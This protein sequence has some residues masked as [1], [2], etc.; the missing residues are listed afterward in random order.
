M[1]INFLSFQAVIFCHTKSTA[2]WL[3]NKMHTEGYVVA[4]LSDELDV[5]Q[6]YYFSFFSKTSLSLSAHI[7]PYESRDFKLQFGIFCSVE[8]I[9]LKRSKIDLFQ[10]HYFETISRWKRESTGDDKCMRPWH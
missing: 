3:A 9:P 1:K 2:K 5:T 10:S 6:R 8:I 4:L 7:L